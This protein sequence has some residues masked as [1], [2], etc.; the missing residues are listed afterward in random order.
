MRIRTSLPAVKAV[1]GVG[2]GGTLGQEPQPLRI[3]ML[4]LCLYHP[5]RHRPNYLT[6]ARWI[7][8][9]TLQSASQDLLG[10]TSS[11]GGF[12]SSLAKSPATWSSLPNPFNLAVWYCRLVSCL[13]LFPSSLIVSL[14]LPCSI[15]FLAPSFAFPRNL[16]IKSIIQSI[17]LLNQSYC[18]V[19]Y[20]TLACALVG[21]LS[22]GLP[23]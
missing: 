14:P 22:L 9:Q 6:W 21:S 20:I 10:S 12:R 1:V 3:S 18:A 13:S 7:R 2:G 4:E 16:Q 17:P 23:T 5:S 19:L 11:E 8:H 15:S